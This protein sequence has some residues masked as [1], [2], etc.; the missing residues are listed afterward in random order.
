LEIYQLNMN[1]SFFFKIFLKHFKALMPMAYYC[2]LALLEI[3]NQ[4]IFKIPEYQK[5]RSLT[6]MEG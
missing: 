6:V 1:K 5:A 4:Y 2:V 3:E